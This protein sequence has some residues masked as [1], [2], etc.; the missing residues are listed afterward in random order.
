M[1]G[2][3]A[4][5]QKTRRE[6]WRRVK[7]AVL[8]VDGFRFAVSP[9]T[10]SVYSFESKQRSTYSFVCKYLLISV[11]ISYPIEKPGENNSRST[12]GIPEW[13]S[14]NYIATGKG[15]YSKWATLSSFSRLVSDNLTSVLQTNVGRF[16]P[17]PVSLRQGKDSTPSGPRCQVFLG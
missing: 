10:T 8:R 3:L 6:L 11:K 17:L 9:N 1:Y 13:C 12:S 4:G 16:A 2:S 7:A 5:A 14:L 15:Q